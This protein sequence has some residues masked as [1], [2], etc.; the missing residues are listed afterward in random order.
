MYLTVI[1]FSITGL[2]NEQNVHK[3]SNKVFWQNMIS[4]DVFLAF[5]GQIAISQ[6]YIQITIIIYHL[7]NNHI[8]Q[9]NILITSLNE[10]RRT[11][12]TE[13]H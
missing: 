4:R 13:M 12:A 8:H 7:G 3:W 11:K 6:K 5:T 1:K 9:G 10:T 2:I